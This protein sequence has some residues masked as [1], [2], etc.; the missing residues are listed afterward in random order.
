M[1]LSNRNT[2]N[3]WEFMYRISRG[4]SVNIE[5][6]A[7]C[8]IVYTKPQVCNL[9]GFFNGTASRD[10]RPYIVGQK[11][12]L[13]GRSILVDSSIF[14]LLLMVPTPRLLVDAMILWDDDFTTNYYL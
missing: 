8:E 2:Q 13:D 12:T 7:Y 1:L 10:S 5:I 9:N 6:V 11:L 14:F 4:S 3:A